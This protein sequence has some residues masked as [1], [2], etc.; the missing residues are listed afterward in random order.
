MGYVLRKGAYLKNAVNSYLND[1]LNNLFFKQ[2]KHT[3]IYI[4]KNQRYKRYERYEPLFMRVLA[5]PFYWYETVRTVRDF[6]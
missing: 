1:Y 3:I 4:R 6:F 5:V 2:D